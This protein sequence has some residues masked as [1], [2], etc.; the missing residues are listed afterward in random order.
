MPLCLLDRTPFYAESGGQVG[1]TGELAE[2]GVMFVVSD[3]QKFAGQFH[4]HVGTLTA[5]TLKRRR[6]VSSA[7]WIT[8]AAQRPCS[9]TPPR[10]CCTPHCATCW[11]ST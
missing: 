6:S 11:A 5:G 10:T 3:T 8:A 9:T 2:Q 4:G 1:D 7:P